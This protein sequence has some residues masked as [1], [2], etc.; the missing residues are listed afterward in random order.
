MQGLPQN[1][2]RTVVDKLPIRNARSM[3]QAFRAARVAAQASLAARRGRMRSS[4][5]FAKVKSTAR[6]QAQRNKDIMKVVTRLLVTL[7]GMNSHE[8]VR[9]RLPAV[10]G[11]AYNTGHGIE[12]DVTVRL[13]T[14]KGPVEVTSS[15]AT[16]D[17]YALHR[18]T[19]VSSRAPNGTRRQ[20]NRFTQHEYNL[21]KRPLVAA[22]FRALK[23]NGYVVPRDP[24][25][26][27]NY[28]NSNDE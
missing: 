1:M 13:E 3:G 11:G 5:W 23:A 24:G 27:D 7:R 4:S 26:P 16:D 15:F 21:M 28:Y 18:A 20:N 9:Y 14:D 6:K 25:Y 8:V 2:L 10:A 12:L 17:A 19:T 22:V